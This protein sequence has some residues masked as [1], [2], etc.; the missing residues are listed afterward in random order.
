MLNILIADSDVK[1][2]KG[3]KS[4]ID[5]NFTEFTVKKIVSEEREF[6]K[7]FKTDTVDLIILE[8]RFLGSNSLQKIKEFSQNN[9]NTKFIVYGNISDTSYLEECLNIG[10]IS[11]A[12]RPVKPID[13]KKCL[14]SAIQY[15]KSFEELKKEEKML[16]M[17]YLQNFKLF[18]HKFLSVLINEI[19]FEK[20]EIENNFDYFNINITAPYRVAIVRIDN[21]RKHIISKTQ[22]EKHILI[23]K[24]LK[25]IESNIK[26]AKAFI[27]L[28]NE[29]VIIFGSDKTLEEIIKIL[30]NIKICINENI[31]LAVSCGVG[32]KY[33]NA[34]EI[35]ISFNEANIALRYRCIIGY[36]SIIPIDYVEPKNEFSAR[37][38]Y[39]VEKNFI[40]SVVIGEYD[41][42]LN[43]LDKIFNEIKVLKPR[44]EE[45]IPEVIFSI[46]LSINRLAFE[47][48][49]KIK[50]ITKFFPVKEI[51]ELNKTEDGYEFLKN[52]I[53]KFCNHTKDLRKNIEIDILN[54][55]TNYINEKYFENITYISLGLQINC[56]PKFLKEI[57]KQK[58]GKTLAEFLEKVRIEKAK[59]MILQTTLTDDII[60]LKIGYDDVSTF[61]K[62]FKK[63]EGCL[64]G[65][66][67][68]IK[69]DLKTN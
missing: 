13:L 9:S 46:V 52:G 1:N 40:Y 29:V 23:F 43:L 38:P 19:V 56:N 16:N 59:E 62:A 31:D 42:S 36:S 27:N 53:K 68:Y 28:F 66:F 24:I 47:Q 21:F 14:N 49:L 8:I 55:A 7:F 54:N 69:K 6:L 20:E 12:I 22:K 65:D 50:N 58:T 3:I 48:G 41:Y 33:K 5:S 35:N 44:F 4:Y 18:E 51:L 17:E 2:L 32:R 30:L 10:A 25:I 57:F 67:R 45:I 61:R 26:N 60:A 37:Y 64:V 15:F 11:Y 39:V 63:L 34:N